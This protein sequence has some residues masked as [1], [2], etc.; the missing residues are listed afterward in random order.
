[1]TDNRDVPSRLRFLLISLV[2]LTW[3]LEIEDCPPRL[4]RY[5][6]GEQGV[7]NCPQYRINVE[8]NLDELSH[9][10]KD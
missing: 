9:V 5:L 7:L 1:M 2:G 10:N 6:P 4:H 8:G 3:I